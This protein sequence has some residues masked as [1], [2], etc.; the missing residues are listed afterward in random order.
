MDKEKKT[1][2]KILPK[3]LMSIE[4]I[5]LAIK[6]GADGIWISNHGGEECL[7]QDFQ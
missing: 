3:G 5:K 6:Y 7:I 1:N 2:L 4:D